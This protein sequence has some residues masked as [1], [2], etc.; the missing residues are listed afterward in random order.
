MFPE[1]SIQLQAFTVEKYNVKVRNDLWAMRMTE[2]LDVWV[3]KLRRIAYY[4]KVGRELLK[5]F[6]EG[7]TTVPNLEVCVPGTSGLHDAETY[8]KSKR[9]TF[10]KKLRFC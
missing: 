6:H 4:V 9:N 10:L 2:K 7:R 8:E 5:Y 1:I 3:R